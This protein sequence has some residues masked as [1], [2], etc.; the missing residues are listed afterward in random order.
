MTNEFTHGYALLVGVGQVAYP[1]WSL[2]VT[3]KDIQALQAILIDPDLCAYPDDDDHIRLLHDAGATGSA[4]LDGLAWLRAQAANDPE[5]TVVVYYSGHGWRDKAAG[6]YYL[7]PHDVEPF[8]IPGSAL[9]AQA[10]TQA[11]RGIPAQRLLVFVDSCH[12]EGMAA[13]KDATI[14]KGESAVKLPAGFEPTALPKSLSNDLKQ[15][16][17]RVVFTSSRGDQRSWV[18]SDGAMSIY[19]YHLLE[20]LQGAGSQPGDA[21]VRVSNLMNHLGQAVPHSAQAQH[22]AEQTPFFDTAT[23]DFPVA[24][25]R[26]GK[27]LPAGGWDAVKNQ[28]A[29]Q[30]RRVY[31]AHLQGSGALAQDRSTAASGGGVAVGGSVGGHVIVAEEGSSVAV[32]RDAQSGGIRAGRIEAENVVDGVQLQGGDAEKAARLVA[33]AQAIRRGGISAEEIKARNLVSGLQYIADPAQASADDLRREVA[34]L[35]ARLEQAVAAGE[36]ADAADAEDAQEA[37]EKAEAE[38]SAPDPQGNR[39]VRKLAETTEILT[40]S[41]QAAQ[42]LGQVG[43][44]IIRLAPVAATLWQIAQRLWGG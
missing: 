6:Q 30:I 36:I 21:L 39:V 19:T 42:A 33:L 22:Q 29:E 24:V 28:A 41:A 34:A 3:V 4:I 15:G 10:F 2:P 27:G 13:A 5:A 12:A 37:L 14:A 32:G 18:R 11:L 31:Q 26:G 17:G 9:S 38:L 8:D 20:A 35:R 16:E 43:R 25:L 1:K 23:E 44:Q 7:I 40:R